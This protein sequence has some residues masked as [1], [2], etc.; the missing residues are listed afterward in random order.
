M[1]PTVSYFIC[2]Q[3]DKSTIYR[4]AFM[5]IY[6]WDHGEKYGGV[7]KALYGVDSSVTYGIVLGR[8]GV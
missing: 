5:I 7:W 3:L 2:A 1:S 8:I 6:R 4:A